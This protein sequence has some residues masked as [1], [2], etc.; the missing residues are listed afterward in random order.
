VWFQNARAKWRRVNTHGGG[1]ASSGGASEHMLLA[2][3]A[4]ANAGS[5]SEENAD[6]SDSLNA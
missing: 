4:E 2:G 6:D 3:G 1:T 5:V